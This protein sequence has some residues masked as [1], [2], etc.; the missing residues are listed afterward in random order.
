MKPLLLPKINSISLIRLSGKEGKEEDSESITLRS[1]IMN[2]SLPIKIVMTIWII[3]FTS[4]KTRMLNIWMSKVKI[5][6]WILLVERLT[7]LKFCSKGCQTRVQFKTHQDFLFLNLAVKLVLQEVVWTLTETL[8][9]S[10]NGS[11]QRMLKR[12][13]RKNWSTSKKE[14][15]GKNY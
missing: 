5:Q 8:H 1:S 14:K 3:W 10:N 9:P 2:W 6:A 7:H 12:G 15:L 4:L 13:L 11:D